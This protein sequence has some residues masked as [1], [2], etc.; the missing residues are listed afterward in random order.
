MGVAGDEMGEYVVVLLRLQAAGAVNEDTAGFEE[1]GGAVE[2]FELGGAEAGDFG[3][4]DAP[5]QIHAP[6]HHAGV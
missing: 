3:G 2:E 4:L 1:G 5:A 6:P